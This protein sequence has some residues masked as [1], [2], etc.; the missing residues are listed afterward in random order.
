MELGIEKPSQET[1][2]ISSLTIPY[3]SRQNSLQYYP[4]QD[5]PLFGQIPRC[6]ED[7]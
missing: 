5:E 7:I 1:L 3:K 6:G 2:F 4:P